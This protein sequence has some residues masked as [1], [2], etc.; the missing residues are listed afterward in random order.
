MKLPRGFGKNYFSL[1][2]ITATVNAVTIHKNVTRV[3]SFHIQ[4]SS[5]AKEDETSEELEELEPTVCESI[6]FSQKACHCN[7]YFLNHT[8]K[9]LKLFSSP[10]KLIEFY[11][12][13][14]NSISP[15]IFNC[16]LR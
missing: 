12:I 14:N 5:Y 10:K 7:C 4:G 11:I 16:K 3:Q 9:T 6:F 2:A 1:N 13:L 15:P 8:L